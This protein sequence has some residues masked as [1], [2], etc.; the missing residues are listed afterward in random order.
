MAKDGEY[1]VSQAEKN[2]ESIE[3]IVDQE[4]SQNSATTP[5]PQS[6]PQKKSFGIPGIPT[7]KIFRTITDRQKMEE[8]W[9][10]ETMEPHVH[11]VKLIILIIILAIIIS[12][13]GF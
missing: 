3:A 9:R 13:L 12:I 6:Q 8:I 7:D 4:I 1:E 11:M 10:D 5:Q 2:T